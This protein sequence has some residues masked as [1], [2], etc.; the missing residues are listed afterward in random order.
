MA[1]FAQPKVFGTKTALFNQSG[2]QIFQDS[3][4]TI[5]SRPNKS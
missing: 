5:P 4:F 3:K 2:K 1:V